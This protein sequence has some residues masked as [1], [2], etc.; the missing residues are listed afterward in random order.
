M[1]T[2]QQNP[3]RA[4]GKGLGA[5]TADAAAVG[6]SCRHW[7]QLLDGP[8]QA[9]T[10]AI[11]QIDPNPVQPRR[12]FQADSL[13]QLADSIR[14]HG[15]IQPLVVRLSGE[16]FQLVAGERRWRAARIAGLS[17]VPAVV[18][19]ISDERLLE[20]TLIEN[21]QREDLNPIELAMA[22]D[23]MA[24]ELNLSQ[25]EIGER[26]GKDRSTICQLYPAAA[27]A[28]RLTA[29]GRG[30]AALRG[31]RALPADTCRRRD[32]AQAGGE[33]RGARFVGAA[34]GT[35]HQEDD[36]A[37]RSERRRRR[38]ARSKCE[39]RY[40]RD[41]T[42]SGDQGTDRREECRAR[43]DRDR[44]LLGG[45]SGS[46]LFGNCG[47]A[48]NCSRDASYLSNF[49]ISASSLRISG[50]GSEN[51]AC[52]SCFI[53]FWWRSWLRPANTGGRRRW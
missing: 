12:V 29:A 11:D 31:T 43:Q 52:C 40:R 34:G 9:N 17:E 5:L 50:I 33:D 41:G 42:G 16:R 19:E 30:T 35:R 46:Y 37:A 28:T 1:T 36:G 13:H 15:I 48:T 4:L 53:S 6:S 2:P 3:R 51:K 14:S 10:I 7:R 18:Q 22:F 24:R 32:A 47:S 25:D 39:G 45:R 49:K 20:I 8:K 38:R 44:I 23:R 21:V 26:T 27:T